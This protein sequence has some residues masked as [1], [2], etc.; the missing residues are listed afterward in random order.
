MQDVKA[1]VQNCLICQQ[2][3]YHALAPV[4]ILQPLPIPDNIWEIFQWTLSQVFLNHLDT[5]N[6][7]DSGL[8]V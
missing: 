8:I 3:K 5:H 1:Y 6:L 7:G 2:A 4:G